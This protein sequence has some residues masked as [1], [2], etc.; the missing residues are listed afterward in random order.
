MLRGSP[1]ARDDLDACGGGE[2]E[3]KDG[4]RMQSGR[5]LIRSGY[6]PTQPVV[7]RIGL[8]LGLGSLRARRTRRTGGGRVVFFFSLLLTCRP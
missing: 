6:S 2:E 3:R 1:A 8:I 4:V 7:A 5:R